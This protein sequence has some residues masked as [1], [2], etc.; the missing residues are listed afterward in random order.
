M[1]AG[2]TLGFVVHIKIKH[3][4]AMPPEFLNCNRGHLVD[5]CMYNNIASLLYQKIK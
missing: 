2:K 3:F 5:A 4:Q 1:E